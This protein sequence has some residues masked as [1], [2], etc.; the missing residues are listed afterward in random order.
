MKRYYKATIPVAIFV[1][2]LGLVKLVANSKPDPEA[3]Q[4]EIEARPVRAV[5]V[6]PQ[7]HQVEVVTQ[8][9]VVPRTEI[10]LMPEVSGKVVEMNPNLVAGGFFEL[11]EVLA[12]IEPR[13]YELAVIRA[14]ARVAEAQQNLIREQAESAQ[15]KREWDE[16]GDGEASPL[17]LRLPQMADAKAK[18]KSAKADLAEAQLRLDRTELRA[19]FAG[20][21]RTRSVDIGQY[22]SASVPVAEIYATSIAEIRLPLSDRQV[23][24]LNLPLTNKKADLERN[25]PNVELR[26]EFG[27]K[28]NVWHGKIVRTEGAI[29][30]VSR[31][32]YAV[33]QVSDPYAGN[34]HGIP[35]PM[36]LFVEVRIDGRIFENVVQVPREAVRQDGSILV[37]DSDNRLH[38]RTAEVLQTERDFAV[39]R[40]QILADEQVCISALDVAT[41][42]MLVRVIE[43]NSSTQTDTNFA[44]EVVQ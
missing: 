43:D 33:A 26:A 18:L 27:G 38:I 30:P 12:R 19:P 28:D 2:G 11:N 23:A 40:A 5:S 13:D 4:V 20:R 44:A 41:E 16:L 9:T 8:G 15:A 10:T 42:N 25:Q 37:I 22:V 7:A 31:V 14:E 17:A 29:D 24:L 35:L 6:A 32:V 34:E 21:V 3:Q 1:V 39:V 36:G